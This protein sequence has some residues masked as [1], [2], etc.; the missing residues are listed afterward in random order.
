MSA[1]AEA[2]ARAALAAAGLSSDV[3][4][5]PLRSVTNEVWVAGDHIVRMNR[6]QDHRLEREA[7]LAALRYIE[8]RLPAHDTKSIAQAR[9]AIAKATGKEAV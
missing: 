5:V 6:R 4:L 7:L 2:R 9:A 3:P 8:G 1:L